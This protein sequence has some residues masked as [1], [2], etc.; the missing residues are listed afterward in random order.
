MQVNIWHCK[1]AASTLAYLWASCVSPRLLLFISLMDISAKLPKPMWFLSKL[2][3]SS[4]RY[5][6]TA[7][8]HLPKTITSVPPGI[9]WSGPNPTEPLTHS[10]VVWQSSQ[11]GNQE[12]TGALS[13]SLPAQGSQMHHNVWWSWCSHLR[14]MVF[15]S[16]VKRF[17]LLQWW[18]SHCRQ[19]TNCS[20]EALGDL[21]SFPWCFHWGTKPRRHAAW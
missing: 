9:T 15:Q 21:A 4:L 2:S 19:F 6:S 5:P 18:G 8:D 1:A 12:C 16:N 7:I 20:V 13:A 17:S 3:F 14:L 10:H 11:R